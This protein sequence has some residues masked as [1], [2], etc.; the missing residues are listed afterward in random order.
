MI[1]KGIY[2]Y[3]QVQFGILAYIYTY[4]GI[5]IFRSIWLDR[6]VVGRGMSKLEGETR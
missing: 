1:L 3:A 5:Y 2:I 6:I 4:I